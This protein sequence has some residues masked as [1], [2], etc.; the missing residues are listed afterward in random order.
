VQL[1]SVFSEEANSNES[2]LSKRA[3][4][5][6]NALETEMPLLLVKGVVGQKDEDEAAI[7]RLLPLLPA[8]DEGARPE[9][10]GQET[11]D[12]KV[13]GDEPPA[14]WDAFLDAVRRCAKAGDSAACKRMHS[15]DFAHELGRVFPDF[16]HLKRVQRFMETRA[17]TPQ[18]EFVTMDDWDCLP[19]FVDAVQDVNEEDLRSDSLPEW[20]PLMYD[21][22]LTALVV[23]KMD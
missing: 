11:F 3:S 21:D 18:G 4:E 16:R 7:P 15:I 2:K 12:T 23:V 20:F 10:Y 6:A 22:L 13:E 8:E 14:V 5:L 17:L 19:I 9:A 1:R